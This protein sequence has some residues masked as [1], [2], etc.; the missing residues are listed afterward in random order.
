MDSKETLTLIQ[1]GLGKASVAFMSQ[2]GGGKIVMP[3]EELIEVANDICEAVMTAH[4]KSIA[5]LKAQLAEA[6]QMVTEQAL[7]RGEAESKLAA[8][9]AKCAKLADSE[10]LWKMAMLDAQAC[11]DQ[12]RVELAA[13]T[14]RAEEAEREKRMAM[15]LMRAREDRLTAIRDTVSQN[16]DDDL[17][18][19]EVAYF[20]DCPQS[21]IDETSTD[22]G[23]LDA[24]R[25]AEEE[26]E[27]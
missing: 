12:L 10:A 8:S 5:T 16:K 26:S 14:V 27:G 23:I 21:E 7:Y 18:R 20:L 1:L 3:T 4:R 15:R 13:A 17:V 11:A 25:Q 9:E 2:P 24:L 19:V 6:H 22:A